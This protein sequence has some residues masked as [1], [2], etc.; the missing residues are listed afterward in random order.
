MSP[1]REACVTCGDVAVEA[2]VVEIRDATALVEVGGR[3]ERVGIE[4]VAP[5]AVGD[6]VLCHAGIALEKVA[7]AP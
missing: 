4:L 2:I 1:D 5:A 6:V 3:L 7:A